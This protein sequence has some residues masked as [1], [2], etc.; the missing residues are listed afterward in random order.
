M[1]I[2]IASQLVQ[3]TEDYLP[4]PPVGVDDD[5]LLA[6]DPMV[7]DAVHRACFDLDCLPLALVVCHPFRCT[8]LVSR[9]TCVIATGMGCH[10]GRM[11]GYD[12]GGEGL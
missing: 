12:C 11:S 3:V 9:S 5:V 7:A 1:W 2:H 10:E 8:A 6:G 4:S